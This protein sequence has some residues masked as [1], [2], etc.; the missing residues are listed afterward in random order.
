M[1]LGP[2]SAGTTAVRRRSRPTRPTDWLPARVCARAPRRVAR[3][4]GSRRA[5]G[6]ARRPVAP[7]RRPSRADLPVVGDWVAV[8]AGD[9]GDRAPSTRCCP[10]A[11]R[12]SA[13]S[14]AASP[15]RRSWPPTST[16]SSSVTGLDGD[17]NLAPRSSAPSRSPGRAAPGRS[18]SSTRP[19]CATTSRRGSPRSGGGAGRAGARDEHRPRGRRR[20]LR[21]LPRAGPRRRAARL[22]RGREVDDHQPA[23][24]PRGR[25]APPRCATT[26]RAAATRRRTASSF[27]LP[28]GGL[29]VDTPGDA[30]V[31][32]WGEGD[33]RRPGVRRHRRARRRLPLPRLPPHRAEPGCA[34]RQAVDDGAARRRAPGQLPQAR[35]RE[36]RH[37][38]RQ[39]RPAR[40][41]RGEAA[42]EVD[43]QAR[44]EAQNKG[45]AGSSKLSRD[46][47]G[48]GQAP[49][50]RKTLGKEV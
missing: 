9:D 20:R 32:L 19:T 29:L 50:L 6:R 43:P 47:Q 24:R 16:S 1:D 37:L 10:G 21:R 27:V 30:R 12:S 2:T 36:L 7:R 34:V 28:S 5:A 17:Y 33:G 48:R 40:R 45:I 22:L 4:G 26:T 15:T 39:G 42:L 8:R 3:P 18:S 23:P 11:A 31:R 46:N 41:P 13:R 44:Q 49:P 14:P 25:C 38:D 35:E